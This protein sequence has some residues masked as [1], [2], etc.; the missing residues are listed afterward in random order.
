MRATRSANEPRPSSHTEPLFRVVVG[1]TIGALVVSAV[2]RVLFGARDRAGVAATLVVLLVFGGSDP[3][4]AGIALVALAIVVAERIAATRYRLRV[5][6]A[7][8]GKVLS[9]GSV[10]VLAAVFIRSATDGSFGPFAGALVSEAPFLARGSSAAAPPAT[11][12]P[13]VYVIILDGRARSDKLTSIFGYQSDFTGQLEKRGFVV[14]SESRSNYLLTAQSL[15]S[16]LNMRHMADLVDR[17]TAVASPLG[18][19][20]EIRRLASHSLVFDRFRE[21]GYDVIA[22]AS[23]FEEVALRGADRFV[24][25]GQINE[26]ELRTVGSTLVARVIQ[27]VD[28]EWFA[29]QHRSRVVSVIDATAEIAGEAHDRPRF[30]LAHVPSPHAPIVF[31]SDGSA[32]PM[33]DVPNFFDDTLEHRAIPRSEALHQD[34]AQ[35]QHIDDLVLPVVDRILSAQR[36]AVVLVISD[37]GSAA[38]LTWSDLAN[39]DLDER[40]ANLFAAYTP[41]RPN[42]FPADISLVNVFGDLFHAYFGDDFTPQPNTAYRW[43][44][45]FINLVQ[46]ELPSPTAH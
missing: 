45:G 9:A 13:D 29:D 6:W 17:D 20:S 40:T 3:R 18:Y 24:D 26:L 5:P 27:A 31:R 36:H 30:V 4:V 43:Q 22:V 15:S 41:G 11:D 16:F 25:T 19:M 46:I 42:L 8:A 1:F 37:H 35:V 33:P 34:A 44:N 12:S 7:L 38:G 23:G 28:P 32:E 21:L 2:C 10:I 14:A 39:S